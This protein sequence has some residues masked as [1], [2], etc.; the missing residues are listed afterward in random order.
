MQCLRVL[1]V[2]RIKSLRGAIRF[3]AYASGSTHAHTGA[4]RQPLIINVCDIFYAYGLKGD[5]AEQLQFFLPSELENIAYI[6]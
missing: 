3:Y 2:L 1:K 6:L 5:T 4:W